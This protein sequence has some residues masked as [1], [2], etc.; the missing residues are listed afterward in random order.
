MFY[1]RRVPRFTPLY[2]S[3]QLE[4]KSTK[5]DACHYGFFIPFFLWFTERSM[6]RFDLDTAYQLA[7]AARAAYPD[8]LQSVPSQLGVEQV[9]PFERGVVAGFAGRWGESVV[10]AFRGTPMLHKGGHPRQLAEALVT[11]LDTGLTRQQGVPGAIHRGFAR[12]LSAVNTIIAEVLHILLDTSQ[13][14]RVWL[15]GH[16]LGGALAILAAQNV[17][18]QYGLLP[19][20]YTYGAPRVGNHTFR[21][22]Y[23]PTH[24]RLE[25]RTDLIPY[26][27]PLYTTGFLRPWSPFS[28]SLPGIYKHTG[29]RCCIDGARLEIGRTFAPLV[30]PLDMVAARL[31]KEH[32]M[33]TY[34]TDLQKRPRITYAE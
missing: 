32:N 14:P 10:V 24:Y 6:D 29:I 21:Q 25:R 7:R 2:K 22:Y 9:T 4:P 12:A 20:V 16:S 5:G 23:K 30:D 8:R 34:L 13:N 27:F 31:G 3:R 17:S 18:R 15:A 28:P 1:E 33:D 26:A 19:C 11:E